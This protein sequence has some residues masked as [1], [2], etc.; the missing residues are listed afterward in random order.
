MTAPSAV[1]SALPIVLTG[2]VLPSVAGPASGDVAT[3]LAEYLRAIEFYLQYAPVIFLENSTYPLER[4]A[5]LWASPGLHVR[6]FAPSLDPA[7]GKGYQEFEMLDAWLASDPQPPARWLKVT[8]RYRVLNIATILAECRRDSHTAL[9]IDQV[10]RA[11]VARTYLFCVQT[12]LYRR[13]MAGLYRRCD[14]RAGDWIERVVFRELR[15]ASTTEAR[16]FRTQ[17]RI[18]AVAGSSGAAFPTGRVQW[19]FKQVLRRANLLFDRQYLWYA[20]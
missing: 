9:L 1:K 14:D 6:R 17:P 3:R 2:T 5:Q 7:R 13:R 15:G 10:P 12:E 19:L 16:F 4:Q 8:G 20:K 11:S 18:A